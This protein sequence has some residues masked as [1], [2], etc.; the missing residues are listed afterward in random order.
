MDI[1][2]SAQPYIEKGSEILN[3]IG[4]NIGDNL[5]TIALGTGSAL[6]VGGLVVGAISV[7]KKR[8][9]SKSK[10]KSRKKKASSRRS[11][12]RK[13]KFGS[14]AWRKKYC[15]KGR[16]QKQPYTAG[17]RKDTSHRRIRYTKNNQ[18]YIILASGKARFIKKSSVSRSRK[19]K[20]GRY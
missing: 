2:L 3:D 4:S 5:G 6:A 18:P 17:K 9:K 7:A 1:P 15:N 16:R 10:S 19:L 20:G 14:K 8:K 12:G 11:G 13:L